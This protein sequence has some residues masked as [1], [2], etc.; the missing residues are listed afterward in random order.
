MSGVQAA[1]IDGE[2]IV[3]DENGVSD[4]D[5]LRSAIHKARHRLVFFAFDLLHFDGQDFRLEGAAIPSR[6]GFLVK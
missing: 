6:R 4:F 2:I 5:A 3:R 1:L